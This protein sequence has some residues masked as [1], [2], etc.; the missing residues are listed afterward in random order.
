MTAL[1][2]DLIK[3]YLR[4]ELDGIDNDVSLSVALA[5]GIEWVERYTGRTI[6]GAD[7]DTVP[8]GLLH[9]VLLYAGAFERTRDTGEPVSLAPATAVCF[10]YRSVLI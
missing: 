8:A 10:P 5:A 6:S 7:P 9:G 4:Y 1:T 2:L 3:A